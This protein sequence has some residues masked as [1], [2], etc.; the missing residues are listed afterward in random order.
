[1]GISER[2]RLS[3]STRALLDDP[4]HQFFLSVASV[5]EANVKYGLNKLKLPQTPELFW[6]ASLARTQTNLVP[7]TLTHTL[8]IH[9]LPPHHRDPFDRMIIVQALTEQLTIITADARFSVYSVPI[10]AP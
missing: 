1:M 7:V 8:A 5:W 4:S 10:M 3:S 9:A 2:A 6:P